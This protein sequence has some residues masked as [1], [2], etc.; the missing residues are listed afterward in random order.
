MLV[1]SNNWGADHFSGAHLLFSYNKLHKKLRIFLF[2][3]V[4]IFN[5]PH[6]LH[7]KAH[8]AK[9]FHISALN[10][11]SVI[12]RLQISVHSQYRRALPSNKKKRQCYRLL[13][14]PKMLEYILHNAHL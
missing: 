3:L 8:I 1:V 4:L 5:K 14:S 7:I 2:F 6:D 12:A 13:N 11:H 10:E 9:F